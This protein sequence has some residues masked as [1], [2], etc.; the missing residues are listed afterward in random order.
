MKRVFIFLFLFWLSQTSLVSHARTLGVSG[1]FEISMSQSGDETDIEVRQGAVRRFYLKKKGASVSFQVFNRSGVQ[2]QTGT[3]LA[4]I[5]DTLYREFP[6]LRDRI[7]SAFGA[8]DPKLRAK[9]MALLQKYNPMGYTVIERLNRKD[10][11]D[12]FTSSFQEDVVDALDTGVHESVHQLDSELES[13]RSGSRYFLLNGVVA[14]A[15]AFSTFHRNEI[16]S[17]LNPKDRV[18]NY[19]IGTYLDGS[20]GRQEF[21]V[22]LDEL[23]AYAHGANTVIELSEGLRQSHTI[24][25]GLIAMM[26]F[27]EKYLTLAQ[28]RHPKTAQAIRQSSYVSLLQGLW[29]Q[30]ERVLDRACA[31]RYASL[32]LTW[33]KALQAL[34]AAQER[35]ALEQVGGVKPDF[36]EACR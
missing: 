11:F 26:G 13:A 24:N 34:Y 33:R 22:L 27:V 3:D 20:S 14:E 25:P 36:P 9:K 16:L 21:P 15:P 29:G 23:N 18:W 1:G 5:P 19:Y 17:L 30:A 8:E 6:G 4:A 7:Q 32:Q 2:I 35:Q 28:N 10:S 12:F 31:S